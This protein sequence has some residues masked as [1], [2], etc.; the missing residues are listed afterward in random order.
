MVEIMGKSFVLLFVAILI[1]LT[2]IYIKV[3]KPWLRL[4]QPVEVQ[5]WEYS[6][7]VPYY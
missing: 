1:I 6:E 3:I 4:F 2:L 5:P 7:Y